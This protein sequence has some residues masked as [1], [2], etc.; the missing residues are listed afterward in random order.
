MSEEKQAQEEQAVP[1]TTEQ[2]APDT[3][4]DVGSLIAESKK[5]RSRAQKSEDKVSDL[6]SKLESIETDKLKD[7]EKWQQLYEKRDQEAKEMEK[8]VEHA[9]T[10]DETLR[11]D[12]LE[13]LN[14]EDREF[15]E[16]MSTA[17]LMKFAKRSRNVVSTDESIAAKRA[18]DGKHPYKDMS[19]K[20]RVSNWQKVVDHYKN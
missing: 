14:E 9:Q 4:T 13:S 12:A 11:Q 5:Y 20:E 15:A 2:E 8:V 18:S 16:E 7:Q 17:K 3:S 10:L 19:Q 1:A 6:E